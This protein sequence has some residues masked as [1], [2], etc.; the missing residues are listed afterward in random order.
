MRYA[1]G[2]TTYPLVLF[3]RYGTGKSLLAELI[4]NAIEG[5]TAAVTRINAEDLNSAAEVRKKFVRSRIFDSFFTVNDQKL[6]YTIVEEVNFDPK[7]KGALRV[8]LDE[9]R[10]R[11]LYI[12]TTNELDKIDDG[13]KSRADVVEVLPAPPDR[14]LPHAQ[15][16]L[17][18]EGI[19]LGDDVVRELLD[20]VYEAERDNRAYCRALDEVID[21]WVEAKQPTKKLRLA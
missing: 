9:M 4:P 15:H 5:T 12:F 16:I 18:S 6:S 14:F 2:S 13:L 7:A 17:R 10:G 20:S 19:E 21:A 3:G 1:D 11:E 8:S